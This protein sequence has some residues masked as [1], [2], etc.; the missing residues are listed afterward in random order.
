MSYAEQVRNLSD[1]EFKALKI[2]AEDGDDISQLMMGHAYVN[3][4]M[5][6]QNFSTAAGWYRKASAN[7]NAEATR[8]LGQLH[9]S[10]TG[11]SYNVRRGK[12]LIARASAHTPSP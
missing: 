12:M 11:V 9:L 2:R 8:A 1:A 10:G 3:S 7:G 6:E 4:M 5:V